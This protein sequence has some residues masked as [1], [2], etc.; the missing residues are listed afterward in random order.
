[1]TAASR[2]A[3]DLGAGEI[4]IGSVE[5]SGSAI[6]V[7]ASI[8]DAI[9]MRVKA[10]ATVH[11]SPDSLI[12]LADRIV[13]ELILKENG[14]HGSVA[15]LPEPTPS[16]PALRAYLAG[17]AGYRRARLL[18]RGS[19][20]QSGA[21]A[22]SKLRVGGP[23]AGHGGGPRERGGAARARPGGGVGSGKAICRRATGRI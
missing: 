18:R 1:M 2:V 17:R 7:N 4:L 12:A 23:W 6:V 13:S 19:V 11:G 3:R 10:T 16:P 5:G 21:D 9:R 8:V 22:G 20:V 15:L 14:D